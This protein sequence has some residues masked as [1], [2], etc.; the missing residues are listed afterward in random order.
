MFSII[1]KII[2]LCAGD[3]KHL[4]QAVW[5]LHPSQAASRPD[6]W[7][8]SWTTCVVGC[9]EPSASCWMAPGWEGWL[10][11]RQQCQAQQ[12]FHQEKWEVLHVAQDNPVKLFGLAAKERESSFA[13]NVCWGVRSWRGACV[14]SQLGKAG[15]L[16]QEE[17]LEYRI[18]CGDLQ[19]KKD[20]NKLEQAQLRPGRW[21]VWGERGWDS[22]V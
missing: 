11:G 21:C 18:Q 1:L 5:C 15:W 10:A 13:E 7:L 12:E 19:A 20:F 14:P 17:Q 4:A 22:L 8:C 2:Q 3:P 16:P 6:A 9:C